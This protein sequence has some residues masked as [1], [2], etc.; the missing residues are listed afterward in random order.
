M[1]FAITCDLD[2]EFC[3]VPKE[4]VVEAINLSVLKYV[5]QCVEYSVELTDNLTLPSYFDVA[6]QALNLAKRV[7][8]DPEALDYELRRSFAS[9][10][11]KSQG[12]F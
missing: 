9:R 5:S 12:R 3:L 7:F 4:W 11:I 2:L 8:K 10:F 1:N 6:N